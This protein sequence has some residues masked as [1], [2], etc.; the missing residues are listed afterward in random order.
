MQIIAIT[1]LHGSL[2]ALSGCTAAL[3]AAV[4]GVDQ[5]VMGT[6][7][8]HYRT[9][10]HDVMPYDWQRYMDFADMHFGRKESE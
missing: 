8:Y 3:A 7:G 9:G 1:D 6:I 5:P 4:P 10:G 2:T